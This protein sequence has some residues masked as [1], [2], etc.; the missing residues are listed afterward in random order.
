M[1][2]VYFARHLEALER[3]L[4]YD[5]GDIDEVN[6]VCSVIRKQGEDFYKDYNPPTDRKVMSAMISLL[7]DELEDSYLPSNIIEIKSK[8]DGN[9]AKYVDNYFKKSFV[10]DYDRFVAF[11]DQP[12]LKKL[13]SDPAYQA[14]QASRIHLEIVG[15]LEHCNVQLEHGA[16]LYMKGLMEM[17]PE[18]DFYSDANST[19]RMNYGNVGDYLPRDGVRYDYFTTLKGVMEKEDPDSYEFVIP[20]RLKELYEQ[21]DYFPYGSDSTI[22]VCFTSNN[23][24]TGGNSGSPVINGRGEVIDRLRHRGHE[25]RHCL[26]QKL[27]KCTNVDI[28]ACCHY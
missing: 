22:N 12:S 20:P 28:R 24:I 15:Q 10:V 3:I 26:S 17:Y 7:I 4:A 21:N 13:R 1:E 18:M 23:D 25:R 8:Y 11:L 14:Y 5:P 16:R 2:S 6:R 9:I 27:Q 19:I